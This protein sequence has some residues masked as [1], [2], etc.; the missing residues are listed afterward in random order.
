MTE[1]Q[2]RLDEIENAHKAGLSFYKELVKPF[3]EKKQKELERLCNSKTVFQTMY[4]NKFY[5]TD[6]HLNRI[7]KNKNMWLIDDTIN[8]F[9]HHV[10]EEYEALQYPSK[11]TIFIFTTT[12]SQMLHQQSK[13]KRFQ[14]KNP[15]KVYIPINSGNTHWYVSVLDLKLHTITYYD[16][17]HRTS[18]EY[19]AT[20]LA[21]LA[22][23]KHYITPEIDD[24][25][26]G[27]ARKIPLQ[28]NAV[29]CGVF[30]CMYIKY[31]VNELDFVFDHTNMMTFRFQIANLILS[32]IKH[33]DALP[34]KQDDEVRQIV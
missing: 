22:F 2:L 14:S 12:E 28:D 26:V 15:D 30:T 34:D 13:V 19:V 17:L 9:L 4:L 24:W 10:N 18:E 1:L 27:I 11:P 20:T 32:H 16:S 5:V 7:P 8:I 29:D 25:T 33:P 23:I 6:K 31:L 3:S 21:T